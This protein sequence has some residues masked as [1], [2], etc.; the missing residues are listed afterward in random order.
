MVY[1]KE[2]TKSAAAEADFNPNFVSLA[3]TRNLRSRVSGHQIENGP[4]EYDYLDNSLE[5]KRVS[6]ASKDVQ[7]LVENITSKNEHMKDR[8]S[9]NVVAVDD[10]GMK[11]SNK[12]ENQNEDIIIDTLP[13]S[14]ANNGIVFRPILV[15]RKDNSSEAKAIWKNNSDFDNNL[16]EKPLITNPTFLG[17]KAKKYTDSVR[18]ELKYGSEINRK[19]CSHD[20]VCQDIYK[21]TSNLRQRCVHNSECGRQAYCCSNPSCFDVPEH[22]KICIPSVQRNLIHSPNVPTEYNFAKPYRGP[23]GGNHGPSYRR[24]LILK[25]K[26][27]PRIVNKKTIHR[28][29]V[30]HS[31]VSSQEVATCAPEN[32]CHY[33]QD[34]SNVRRYYTSE[35]CQPDEFCCSNPCLVIEENS[36]VCVPKF[37][38]DKL[39]P[40]NLDDYKRT[41]TYEKPSIIYETY[42]PNYHPKSNDHHSIKFLESTRNE[43]P[44]RSRKGYEVKDQHHPISLVLERYTCEAEKVCELV[45]NGEISKYNK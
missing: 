13:R 14:S 27:V 38:K 25:T 11:H 33:K 36:K 29:N 34:L 4:S 9:E 18:Y 15:R 24:N 16:H 43:Q 35:Q 10:N 7:N 5:S 23:S 31:H 42:K 3:S 39:S 22:V 19:T 26:L 6:S 2:E 40:Y 28:H 32:V 8:M 45:L 20:N 21:Q 30:V 17:R 37:Q 44:S 1:E 12:I 41:L